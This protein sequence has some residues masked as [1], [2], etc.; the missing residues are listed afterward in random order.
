VVSTQSTTRYTPGIFFFFFFWMSKIIYLYSV[1]FEKTNYIKVP[2]NYT[3]NF[4]FHGI[5][6]VVVGSHVQLH[7]GFGEK[8]TVGLVGI[9]GKP[10]LHGPQ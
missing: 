7:V 6:I 9:V 10:I 3:N 4:D 8:V 5:D 2:K 1:H